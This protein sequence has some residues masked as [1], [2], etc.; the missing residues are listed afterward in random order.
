[1]KNIFLA[2]FGLIYFLVTRFRNMLYNKGIFKSTEFDI[3]IISVGN[4]SVGGNGKTPMVEYLV[5]ELSDNFKI[6]VLSRGYGR[7]S[8]GIHEVHA[9]SNARQSGDEPLQIKRKFK[10]RVVVFVGESR[11]EAVTVMLFEHPDIQLIILDDAFQHR[12]IKPGLNLLLTEYSSIF[13]NDKILPVGRLREDKS[14]ANRADMILVT[15]CLPS[16]GIKD[17]LSVEESVKR[18]AARDVLFSRQVNT[19]PVTI[20]NKILE[21]GAHVLAFCG[22]AKPKFFK[23]Y[24]E[25]EFLVD[26]FI[27]FADHH[28]FSRSDIKLL[29]DKSIKLNVDK[30]VTTEKDFVR[31]GNFADDFTS[32]NIEIYF[33]GVNH[34]FLNNGEEIFIDTLNNY[35]RESY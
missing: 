32:N 19:S 26:D 13:T 5:D 17:M 9:D 4:I 6:G 31:L 29:I 15:K 8:K 7:K 34:Q 1:M 21:K 14:G 3:P 27:S 12:A 2:P 28:N 22:I 33:T 23:D 24:L 18:F 25:D 11:V 35:V 10:E 20:N 16:L 30:V